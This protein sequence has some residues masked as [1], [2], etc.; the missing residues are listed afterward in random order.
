MKI[1][2]LLLILILVS[3]LNS[4]QSFNLHIEVSDGE[5]SIPISNANIYLA[6]KMFGTTN[7]SGILTFH[8]LNKDKYS[9]K[10]THISYNTFE[11]EIVLHSDTTLTVQ[12]Y[13]D[14]IKLNDIIVTSGKYEKDINSLPFSVASVKQENIKKSASVTVSDL[15]K[16]NPAFHFCE[17]EFGVLK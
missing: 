6:G 5:K 1:Y 13:P 10:I 14:S 17:M 3:P 16:I 9:L 8:N 7:D 12:L 15:L 4:A 2:L 11:D